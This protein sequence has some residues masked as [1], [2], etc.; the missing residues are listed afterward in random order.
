MSMSSPFELKRAKPAEAEAIFELVR[1]AYAKWI[2]VLGRE[3]IPMT[4]DYDRA[5]RDNEVDVLYD[6][7]DMV[8]LIQTVERADD[9][10]IESVAVAPDWQGAGLGQRLLRHAEAKARAGK[11]NRISLQM[12]EIFGDTI[13]HYE[14]AGFRIDGRDLQDDGTMVRMSKDLA[15]NEVT[16]ITAAR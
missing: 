16:A 7:R 6:S 1:A 8:A 9:L 3:P 12:N 5:V 2:P 14:A 13:R 15:P 11:R 10:L 4:A